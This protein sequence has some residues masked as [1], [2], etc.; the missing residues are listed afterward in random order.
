MRIVSADCDIELRMDGD[1]EFNRDFND[2]VR[3]SS[4]GM[5]RIDAREHGTRRELRIEPRG[6]GLERVYRLNGQ[7]RPFDAEGQAWLADFLLTLER[8]TAMAV[9]TRLPRLLEQGGV[10][11]VFAETAQMPS[12]FA[13][14]R[15]YEKLTQVRS[16]STGETAQMLTQVASMTKS[17]HYSSSALSRTPAGQLSNDRVRA[18]AFD[19]VASMDSDHYVATS[20]QTILKSAAPS[21]DELDFLVQVLDRVKSDH[22]KHEVLTFMLRG[23]LNARHRA[24][25]ATAAG[26]IRS[27]HYASSFITAVTELPGSG[28]D[29]LR[30]L[31][32]AIDGM[33]SDHYEMESLRSLL[34][35][36]GLNESDLLAVVTRAARVQSDHSQ[37]EV[38]TAA[39]RH[40][41][42]TA[43]VKDA[44]NDAAMSL[45][46]HY[47]EQVQRA[48]GRIS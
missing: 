17:D 43:R 27:D 46:R 10:A 41:A 4:G 13:R 22:Y 37:S 47:R 24:A 33:S 36:R 19:V 42:A 3:I 16:L 29:D 44:A 18:A 15:Y 25:L 12:D 30:P 2:I 20:L 11:A 40:P 14:D 48:T 38:L 23:N 6:N 34:R 45:S 28:R 5:F 35:L 39:V 26:K 31:L 9:D 8:R 1:I 32:A 7:E 21:D